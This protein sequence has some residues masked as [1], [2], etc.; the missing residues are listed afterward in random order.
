MFKPT[1]TLRLLA[2][3]VAASLLAACRA[4]APESHSPTLDLNALYTQVAGTLIAQG[5]GQGQA[6]ATQAPTQTPFVVTATPMATSAA[7]LPTTVPTNTAPVATGVP[8]TGCYQAYFVADIS[9]PDNTQMSKGQSFTKTWRIRNNGTCTWSGDFDII[10]T[11]GTNL[12]S[13]SSLDIPKEVKP[14]ETVDI[15]IPMTAPTNDGTYRSSWVI[16][17]ANGYTFGVNGNANSAGVPFFALIRVGVASSGIRYDFAANYC[18]ASWS[19]KAAG[20]LPCPGANSGTAGFVLVLQNPEL[21]TRNEDEPAIWPRP[22]H[23]SDGYIRGVYPEF[24]VQAGD[25]FISQVG[26]LKNNPNCH[27][28][29]TLSYIHNGTETVLGTWN[30]KSEGLAKDVNVDLASLAGKTVRFVLTVKP[31]NSDYAQANGFWFVPR[32]FNK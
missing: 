28:Q 26:C 24:T 17:A 32:I 29:F 1:N 3:L 20:S 21:E 7:A 27:L 5:Q 16:K 15:S 10:Y 2:L 18:S 9:V 14:G 13:V 22:N 25:R 31:N 6:V 12:A 11:S 19:T 8:A 23:A 30:E 4:P